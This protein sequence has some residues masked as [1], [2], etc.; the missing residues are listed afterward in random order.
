[1]N[2]QHD[3]IQDDDG[4]QV[5][6]SKCHIGIARFQLHGRVIGR[7]IEDVANIYIKFSFSFGNDNE[8]LGEIGIVKWG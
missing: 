8:Y 6:L 3:K 1:M 2:P 7:T 5:P 4:V